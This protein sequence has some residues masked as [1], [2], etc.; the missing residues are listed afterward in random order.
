MTSEDKISHSSPSTLTR[1]QEAALLDLLWGYMRRDL[2]PEHRKDRV[3]TGWGTKTKQGLIACI[4]RIVLD[5][6]LPRI[7]E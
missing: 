2:N 5:G 1:E 3:Q 6:E 4:K 7:Q